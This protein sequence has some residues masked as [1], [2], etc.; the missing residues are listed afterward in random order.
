MTAEG[1]EIHLEDISASTAE[2]TF[3]FHECNSTVVNN[4]YTADE[5]FLLSIL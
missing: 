5:L 1:L 4:E 2:L 3:A